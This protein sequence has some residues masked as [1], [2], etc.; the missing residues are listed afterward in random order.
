MIRAFF[1]EI[2]FPAL[3]FLL[4]LSV[5]KSFM[6]GIRT[7]FNAPR[8]SPPERAAERPPVQ[9]GGELK[10]DPVCGTYVS[11]AVSLSRVVKGQP[12]YFCSEECSR[13][14]KG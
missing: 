4:L 9:V 3:V 11:T 13:K 14:F 2:V 7:A 12:V 1:V 6:K 5:A 8:Q 10:K